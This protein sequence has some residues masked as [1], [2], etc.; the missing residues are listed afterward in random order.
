MNV[1]SLQIILNEKSLIIKLF[2]LKIGYKQNQ[3]T[4]VNWK[5]FTSKKGKRRLSES[6]IVLIFRAKHENEVEAQ[7]SEKLLIK[8]KCQSL[9]TWLCR[10]YCS[11][12]ICKD[13]TFKICPLL[14][15]TQ[16]TAKRR[17]HVHD[18]HVIIWMEP[19]WSLVI[20]HAKLQWTLPKKKDTL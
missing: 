10:K 14:F 4:E 1:L 20:Y 12:I 7:R 6:E 11:S 13:N 8:Q 18:E 17:A 15:W 2:S 16:C 3:D 19:L 5:I 9:F